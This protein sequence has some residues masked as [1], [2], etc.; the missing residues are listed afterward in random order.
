MATQIVMPQLGESVAEGIIGKWLK[1]EGD[2]VAKDE[3][4]VEIV[5]DKVNAEI[6]SPVAGV[7]QKISAPEGTTVAVGQEIAVIA[8]PGDVQTPV[9]TSQAEA[10]AQPTSATTSPSA[11][12]PG[13]SAVGEARQGL[14][15]AV[16]PSLE[17]VQASTPTG[18]AVTPTSS[19]TGEVR[20]VAP[21][22]QKGGKTDTNGSLAQGGSSSPWPLRSVRT[23]PLV[24][25]LAAEHNI[26]L[27]RVPGTGIGGRVSKKDI[28]QYIA[29]MQEQQQVATVQQVPTTEAP[30]TT[31]P[32]PAMP[33]RPSPAPPPTGIV[34]EQPQEPSIAV[35][36]RPL[37][38]DEEAIP[39]SPVRRLIAEHMVKSK[40][41]LPH[42][43]TMIEV[44]MTP[45]VQY[46]EAHKAQW[47]EREGIS[48]SYLAFIAKAVVEALK[49]YPI[50]N[51]EWGGDK[52]IIK[53]NIN[54]G[55][56]VAAPDG[57]I[58]PIIKNADRLSVA[59]L[60]HAIHDLTT[61]A[62][63][64]Q[65]SPDDV[66][67]GTFTL[68]N[69]GA[70]GSIWSVSI[71]NYPQAGILSADAIVKRVCVMPGDS[72]AIRH[73]MNLSMSFDH[74]TLDGA[75]VAEFMQFIRR[76]L[77]NWPTDAPLY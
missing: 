66:A 5:T 67:G 71:I 59:G 13:H 45:V 8:E 21:T 30:T 58:V 37:G 12:Q 6:P 51:S 23:S 39:V 68:N 54:L 35:T 52:I 9:Q 77:E 18:K 25:R 56:A 44:D 15:V 55:I 48:L 65:L 10:P 22:A 3:P 43:T 69:T 1:Q 75:T 26:D 36:A 49:E 31:A 72:I 34:R 16:T 63:N 28:L 62:R 7:L 33:P 76:R 2:T 14:A 17:G 27:T 60:A 19:I 61:R 41:T 46:R 38:T 40:Y 73:I 64:R 24:Q 53:K 57:L 29:Q 4:I 50:V 70:L 74:R 20:P 32:A 47:Q 42:A 11:N